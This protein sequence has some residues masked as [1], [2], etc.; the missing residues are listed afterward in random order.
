MDR[1]VLHF[2]TQV[3]TLHGELSEA[4]GLSRIACQVSQTSQGFVARINTDKGHGVACK[5]PRQ[6]VVTQGLSSSWQNTGISVGTKV[7][8]QRSDM[9]INKE[10]PEGLSAKDPRLKPKSSIGP[11]S[12][13]T[14]LKFVSQISLGLSLVMTIWTSSFDVWAL[15]LILREKRKRP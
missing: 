6:H 7:Q 12:V 10:A 3:M 9:Q 4:T 2:R 15:A 8:K 1:V 13:E 14:A 11:I 5:L